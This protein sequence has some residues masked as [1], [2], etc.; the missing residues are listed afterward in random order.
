M[1]VDYD[2]VVIG[3]S[4][5]GIYAAQKAVQLQARVALVTS[6][7]DLFLPNDALVNNILSEVGCWNDRLA[8][9][10]VTKVSARVSLTAAKDCLNRVTSTIQTKNSLA[11]LAA[12]GVDVITGKGEFCRLPHLAFQT[13]QRKLRSRAFLLA[14]GA[15]YASEFVDQYGVN[16]YLTLRDLWQTDLASL[17]QEIIIVGSDPAALE[18][19]QT[20]ARFEKTITL[21]TAQSRILPLED[22]EF[23]LLLQAQ[24][25]AE[26]IKLYLNS[27]MSQ[28]KTIDGQK[29]V[30]AGDRALSAEQ[31][32]IA[33]ARQPNIAGLNLAGVGVKYDR[34]RVY[35][36]RKLQTTNPNIYA[37]GDIIGGYSLPNFARYEANVILKNTLFFPWYRANYHALPWVISTQ[38]NFARV[39]LTTQQAQQQYGDDLYLVTEYFADL[40]RSPIGD[41]PTGMCKLLV[42]ENGEIVGCSLISDRAEELI[43]AIALMMQHQIKLESNPMRGLTSLSLPTTYLSQSEIWQRVW[44]NYYQQKLQ[45]NPRLLNRLRSWCSLR[46]EWHQ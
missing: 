38:P 46:K 5:V 33:D 21:V 29:W 45:R 25:E 19:A 20:L 35:V 16:N 3:S 7:D 31:I 11:N 37:C 8:N 2:L 30:Q 18:L 9:N 28:I 39:G 13:A 15:N 34:Q 12:L 23:A 1:A 44:N 42:R 22:P 26:G 32:I 14:T 24:L 27:P 40:E 10:P 36:N 43:T 6:C 41:Y 17:G 4:W